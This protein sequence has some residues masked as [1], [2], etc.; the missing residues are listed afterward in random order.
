MLTGRFNY[1]FG[2]CT[3]ILIC[4]Y[5]FLPLLFAKYERC[6]LIIRGVRVCMFGVCARAR[7]AYACSAC[8]W[9]ACLY[10]VCNVVCVYVVY[11]LC[12]ICIYNSYDIQEDALL[13]LRNDT[14]MRESHT[15][16]FISVKGKRGVGHEE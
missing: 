14:S 13:I 4:F 1:Q 10:D 15:L 9:C 6:E 16:R 12:C 5:R 7:L 2:S 3:K 8:A 11:V